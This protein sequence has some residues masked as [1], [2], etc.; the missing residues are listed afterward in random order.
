MQALTGQFIE[1]QEQVAKIRKGDARAFEAVYERYADKIYWTARRLHLDHENAQGIVQQV[2]LSLWEN[3]QKLD[4]NLSLNA[5][6]LTLTK[7]RVINQHKHQAVILAY[8]GDYRHCHSPTNQ[9]TEDAVLYADLQEKARNFIDQLP[10][11]KK[12]IFLL[13]HREDLSNDEIA[14][15]LRLS[16]RTVENNLYQA[17]QAIRHFLG[18]N[19]LLE[20]SF[21]LLLLWSGL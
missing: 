19:K 7:N 17:E 5:Y 11:R 6:L 12:Q 1:S 10:A 14:R 15:L 21:Y 9:A 18:K 13:R 4:E 16:K 20:K 8:A 2:F 3:R